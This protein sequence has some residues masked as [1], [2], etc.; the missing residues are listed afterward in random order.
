MLNRPYLEKVHDKMTGKKALEKPTTQIAN[1]LGNLY[2]ELQ[3]HTRLLEKRRVKF[4]KK[5]IDTTILDHTALLEKSEMIDK[6]A[7]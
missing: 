6:V 2:Q 3:K 5:Q 7:S 4:Q 1:K